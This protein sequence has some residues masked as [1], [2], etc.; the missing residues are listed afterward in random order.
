MVGVTHSSP[1]PSPETP[2]SMKEEDPSIQGYIRYHA[3]LIIKRSS[4]KK[5][6]SEMEF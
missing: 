3:T 2:T 4:E 5:Y 1:K 6:K